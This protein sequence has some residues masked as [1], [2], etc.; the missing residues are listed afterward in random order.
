M[1]EHFYKQLGMASWLMS[2]SEYHELWPLY[3]I[4]IELVPPISLGQCLFFYDENDCP[5]AFVTWS[6]I[7]E[8]TKNRLVYEQGQMQWEDW[9]AGDLL[10]FNDFV[11]PFGHAREVLAQLRSMDWPH[12]IAFSLA[13]ELDGDIKKVRYWWHSRDRHDKQLATKRHQLQLHKH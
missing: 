3:D 7:T 13:R 11:A 9:D 2:F 5:V 1:E 10:L 4:E 12:E 6:T 8:E